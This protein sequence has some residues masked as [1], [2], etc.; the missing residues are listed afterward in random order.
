MAAQRAKSIAKELG[1]A[2]LGDPRRSRRLESTAQ[3][4]MER[5]GASLPRAMMGEAEL[6]GAYRFLG[7]KE[8][9]PPRDPGTARGGDGRPSR[10]R[11]RGVLHQ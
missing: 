1:D 4:L 10:R 11:W 5:P 6:E 2:Q 9:R 3:R 8:V 7:N